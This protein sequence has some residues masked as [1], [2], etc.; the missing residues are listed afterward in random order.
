MFKP[1]GPYCQSCSMPLS[2]DENGGGTNADG[3]KNVEYCSH[4]YQNGQFTE[5][6]ITVDQMIEKVKER[7]KQMHIPGF[8]TG[9]FTKDIPKLKRWQQSLL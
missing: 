8:L 7:L 6:N 4:C 2:K 3:S 1:K 9:F 5:P